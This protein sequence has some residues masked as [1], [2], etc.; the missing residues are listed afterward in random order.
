MHKNKQ[1]AG[2]RET[3]LDRFRALL[4][5]DRAPSGL[6]LV[7][8]LSMVHE[9]A[10]ADDG[11]LR[12]QQ[13]AEFA[14]QSEARQQELLAMVDMIRGSYPEIADQLFGDQADEVTGGHG[15]EVDLAVLAG[16]IVGL[17]EAGYLDA[18]DARRLNE[19]LRVLYEGDGGGW[20]GEDLIVAQADAPAAAEDAA[21]A[22]SGSAGGATG[23][24]TQAVDIEALPPPGAGPLIAFGP[25]IGGGAA[26]A[27][28]DIIGGGKPSAAPPDAT[29]PA[30]VS[31]STSI[32]QQKI[33]LTYNEGLSTTGQPLAGSFQVQTSSNGGVSWTT[34]TITGVQVSGST[35]VISL[36]T[37]ANPLAVGR[38]LKVSYTDPTT[39]NDANAIQDVA[40]NDA[41]TVVISTGI[42]ADGYVRGAQIYID[43]NG[44]G[45]ADASERLEGVVTDAN[46]N[47][48]LS[49]NV[50][51]GAI[52]AV[53]GVNIDTGV[54]NTIVMK[55]P[56][57]STM[58][59][60]LTTL[61]QTYI[62]QNGGSVASANAA[63][64]SALNLTLPAGQT[65]ATY[66]PLAILAS[67]PSDATALTVQ[68]AAAQVATVV[69]AAAASP[70]AGSSAATVANN[71]IANLVNQ[72]EA[73]NAS[74][75]QVD[76]TSTSVLTTVLASTGTTVVDTTS[77]K[78]ATDA[79]AVA[80]NLSTVVQAQAN[81]LD[82]IA[83]AAPTSLAVAASSD[84]GSSNTDGITRDTTPTVRVNLN[85][86]ATDGTAAVA[87]NTVKIF[88]GA[89]QLG[90]A[91][92]TAGNISNGYVDITV[93]SLALGGH[94]LSATVTDNKQPP[95][96]SALST[97]YGLTIEATTP[98]APAFGLAVDSGTSGTDG[99][100]NNG[101]A[102]VTGLEPGASFQYS[103]DGGSH[104]TNGSGSS[105]SLPGSALYLAGTVQVRQV[106]V[107]GNTGAATAS[108]SNITVG[109]GT[110]L[111]IPTGA[112]ETTTIQTLIAQGNADHYVTVLDLA[113][114]ATTLNSSEAAALVQAG[115][116]FAADDMVTMATGTRL[117]TSLSNLQH[118][119][120]D[121]ITVTGTGGEFVIPAGTG[122]LDYAHLP[123]VTADPSVAVGLELADSLQNAPATTTQAAALKT[124]GIDVLMAA[125]GSLSVGSAQVEAIHTG[126]LTFDTA[127][128]LTM[129][130]ASANET[131]A[132]SNLVNAI[133][134]STYH[135]DVDLLHALDG[136]IS[137]TDAQATALVGAGLAFNSA[138]AVTVDANVAAQGSAVGTHLQTS[139]TGLQQLGVD[140]INITGATAGVVDIQ[141]GSGVDLAHLP[142]I[143][144]PTGVLVGLEMS[145]AALDSLT[146]TQLTTLATHGIDVLSASD[147]TI[148]LDS[149]AL[150]TVHAHGLQLNPADT[151]TVQ[152][153]SANETAAVS[154]LVAVIGASGAYHG[155][156]DV[157]DV[158]DNAISITDVQAAT[159]VQAGLH[160]AADDAGVALTQS[161]AAGTHLHTS[162]SD[163]Q[164][165][166]VDYVHTEAGVDTVVVDASTGPIPSLTALPVFDAEDKVKLVVGDSHVADMANFLQNYNTSVGINPHIDQLDVVLNTTLGSTA[167]LGGQG[168][169]DST[170]QA[171]FGPS[172]GAQHGIELNVANPTL[173]EVTL[174]MVL[175]AADASAD[176][177]HVLSGTSL[178]S[179]L[180][181]AG[182]IDI[183]IDAITNFSVSDSDLKPLLDAGLIT[184]AS[185]AD[186]KVTNAGADGTLD[187]SL[188][189]LA[190]I[191]ADHVQTGGATLT[192]DAGVSYTNLSDLQAALSGLVNAFNAQGVGTSASTALFENS[193]TVELRVTGDLSGQTL[194]DTTLLT[195]LQLLGIDEIR[196]EHGHNIKPS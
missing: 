192:L 32:A 8:L 88:E 66:D 37:I 184:A 69:Q 49:D 117:S 74:S 162:L 115:L 116:E 33:T 91:V 78:T 22:A 79:I 31:T 158:V 169:Y 180:Q 90:L 81:L 144:A 124:A 109:L 94:S 173:S 5:E 23:S 193:D 18:E 41:A 137:I 126:G 105:F 20:D 176:S 150:D 118:L 30:Y 92:L 123:T 146:E 24:E 188:A 82:T 12:A 149:T 36:D 28:V 164:H 139:M 181:A 53:G 151:V 93:S 113:D 14:F 129:E 132:I 177:L 39:G 17:Q 152:I 103:T 99:I 196:D 182:V 130:I 107:I 3:V 56:A 55:A 59:S 76:L 138:D 102:N 136:A 46:G 135:G 148:T 127:D 34:A 65:L 120:V 111:T 89:T 174:G 2:R 161:H 175:D 75:T 141:V 183:H 168:I 170:I 73:A 19:A 57:G 108:S 9:L 157:L 189:Q 80:G 191:G 187:V 40:G 186:V 96:V 95:Y 100:T 166:G 172:S 11:E 190:N 35:V 62:E 6:G 87:G 4:G 133:G 67:N 121:A 167:G 156:V 142:Q 64:V 104:W 26:I 51:S 7:F 101:T 27:T 154:G 72:V 86:T 63:V 110:P 61:V 25:V 71:V 155:D 29:A 131:A 171:V 194:N 153:A 54:P 163:L 15:G 84:T 42:V 44:N 160:F 47:F 70:T 122:T 140:F 52:L 165:L 98:A 185:G 114:N 119:G 68:K 50:A 45:V 143:S 97:A 10:R 128:A 195:K 21:G 1:S 125:D 159:L 178:A 77:I 145:D 38:L 48:F 83:P 58:I 134:A 13:L 112:A 179:E 60:P 85:V 43:A 16:E 106:D 147:A